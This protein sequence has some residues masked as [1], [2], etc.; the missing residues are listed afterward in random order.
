MNLWRG[1]EQ[2]SRGSS[3][4]LRS[5]VPRRAVPCRAAPSR[6]TGIVALRPP[7]A[8]LSSLFLRYLLTL[9]A[10]T[11]FP[12]AQAAWK[13]CDYRREELKP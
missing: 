11:Y 8:L 6:V 3:V 10:L 13:C 5:A 12:Y 7:R 4:L 1:E 9:Q 2:V